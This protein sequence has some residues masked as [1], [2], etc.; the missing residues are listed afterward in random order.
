MTPDKKKQTKYTFL[1]TQKT[2]Q[3]VLP[4]QVRQSV[5][6]VLIVSLLNVPAGQG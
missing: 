3:D 4:V 6:L 5:S 2:K 1:H